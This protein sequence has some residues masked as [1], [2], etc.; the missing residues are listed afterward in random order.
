[1]KNLDTLSKKEIPDIRF[2]HFVVMRWLPYCGKLAILGSATSQDKKNRI[3]QLTIIDV[4][5]WEHTSFDLSDVIR[6]QELFNRTPIVVVKDDGKTWILICSSKSRGKN[7][8]D[9]NS[10]TKY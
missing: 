1:M 5:T 10:Y 9:K 4:K 8:T 7:S 2:F 3:T 6:Y